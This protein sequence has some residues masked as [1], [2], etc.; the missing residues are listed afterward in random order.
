MAGKLRTKRSWCS[1][2]WLKRLKEDFK[3]NLKLLEE[4]DSELEKYEQTLT[5]TRKQLAEK[6]SEISELKIK[7]DELK[8][9]TNN[10]KNILDECKKY[11]LNRLNQKQSEIDKYKA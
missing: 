2:K 8:K 9:L 11:Y 3:Y 7:I 10:E 6:N 5:A 4:R 1:D